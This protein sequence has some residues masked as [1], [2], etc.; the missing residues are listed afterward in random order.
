[1][2][3]I[4]MIANQQSKLVLENRDYK[5]AIR[6]PPT[7]LVGLLNQQDVLICQRISAH[8]LDYIA[9]GARVHSVDRD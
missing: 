2:R 1:M 8:N 6:K 9:R 3:I 7:W 4:S 5:L